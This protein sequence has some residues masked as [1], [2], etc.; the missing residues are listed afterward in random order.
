MKK[1]KKLGNLINSSSNKAL[2]SR[3]LLFKEIAIKWRIIA[4][5]TIS[6]RTIPNKITYSKFSKEN[7]PGNLVIKAD[8]SFALELQHIQDKLIEKI[9]SFLGYS[10]IGSITL[11]QAPIVIPPQSKE[12]KRVNRILPDNQKLINKTKKFKSKEL[13]LALKKLG[14][15]ALTKNS[16]K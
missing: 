8:P 3:G 13:S 1:I 10:A 11:L 16:H 7:L 15:A 12:K 5:E 14:T 2:S 6:M 4:G 9:N